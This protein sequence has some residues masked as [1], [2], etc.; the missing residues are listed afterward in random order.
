MEPEGLLPCSQEPA[1]GAYAEYRNLV[2]ILK[3]W[4]FMIHFSNS[5]LLLFKIH[6]LSESF[7]SVW[8]PFLVTP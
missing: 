3:F 7:C 8:M 1:T 6:P 4:L 2:H 5:V